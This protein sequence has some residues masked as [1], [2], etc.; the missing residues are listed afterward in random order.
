M[1]LQAQRRVQNY[2]QNYLQQLLYRSRIGGS[3]N[4]PP[5]YTT[6][7]PIT[8]TTTVQTT[9]TTTPEQPRSA[10]SPA[11]RLAAI[12][13]KSG[14]NCGLRYIDLTR[15]VFLKTNAREDYIRV[16]LFFKNTPLCSP[17]LQYKVLL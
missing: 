11:S 9:T 5:Y 12:I 2:Y 10:S 15:H 7:R 17:Y 14:G 8:T 1:N 3:F 16:S 4:N 6:P 13:D